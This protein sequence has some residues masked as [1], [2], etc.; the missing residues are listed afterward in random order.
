MKSEAEF[1]LR[2]DWPVGGQW[3]I[4]NGTAITVP[5]DRLQG[6]ATTTWHGIALPLPL[7]MEATALNQA[8][9]DMLSRWHPHC[10]HLLHAKNGAI[11]RSLINV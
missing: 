10:L 3:L 4:P 1:V 9:A 2:G 7:P 5:A 6:Y 8:A 11:I